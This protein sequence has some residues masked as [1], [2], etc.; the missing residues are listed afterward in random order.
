MRHAFFCALSAL[1]LTLSGCGD[2]SSA[3]T[4]LAEPLRVTNGTYFEG[5]FPATKTTS[6]Q[7]AQINIRNTEFAAGTAGKGITGLADSKSQS[8]ALGLQ[9]LSHG[10][11][12]VPVGAPDLM[13]IGTFTWSA[14]CDFSRDI[15]VGMHDLDVAAADESGHFGPLMTAS[16]N[17]Q[18]FIPAGHV[19]A[20]LSWGVDADLDLH[21]VGPSGKELDPKHPN[22]TQLFDAGDDKGMPMPGNGL[23][24]HDSLASCYPDGLR[25]ENVVWTDNPE[26]GGYLVRVDMFNACGKPSASFVF[27]LYVDGKRVLEKHGRLLDLNADGGGPGSGLFV[28]DFSCKGTGTC[29]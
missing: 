26:E 11:W 22:S 20:S 7:V 19:V 29:S 23:L 27:S 28:T 5:D 16:L 25:T 18:P 12:V 13:T 14:N 21:L 1:S 6:P 10:Y 9:G 17:I 2:S 4:G 15:P 8:V 24:D 3:H